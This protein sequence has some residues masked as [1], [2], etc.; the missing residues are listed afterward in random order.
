M[1]KFNKVLVFILLAIVPLGSWYYLRT[2]LDYRKDAL[3]ELEAK[4]NISDKC[5]GLSYTKGFTTV[6]LDPSK[7]AG[8]T[9]EIDSFHN[10]LLTKFDDVPKLNIISLQDDLLNSEHQVFTSCMSTGTKAI[11]LIDTSGQVRMEYDGS[12]N[13]FGKVIEH[14]AIVLPRQEEK[15]IKTKNY[16]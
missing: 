15:D 2:G 11:T 14:L 13:S 1:I 16:K 8:K 10:V 5:R 4:F 12:L 7:T 3:K 6:L 9:T